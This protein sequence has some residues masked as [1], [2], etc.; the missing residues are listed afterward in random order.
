L[1]R[2]T[3]PPALAAMLITIATS[4]AGMGAQIGGWP[5]QVHGSLALATLVINIWACGIE[6][7]N[8]RTNSRVIEEVMHE[9]ERIRAERG[10]PRNSQALDRDV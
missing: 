2:K 9:V 8:I 3:F 1:K 10:L 4:A 7:R 6:Y 5:W